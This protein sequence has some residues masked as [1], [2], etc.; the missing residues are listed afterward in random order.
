MLY[1]EFL[2]L[3]AFIETGSKVCGFCL[4]FKAVVSHSRVG[5][6]LGFQMS[7]GSNGERW[8]VGSQIRSNL[9]LC[10]V[11]REVMLEPIDNKGCLR[12]FIVSFSMLESSYIAWKIWHPCAVDQVVMIFEVY[13]FTKLFSGDLVSSASYTFLHSLAVYNCKYFVLQTHQKS[14]CKSLERVLSTHY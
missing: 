11:S 12:P 1:G 13:H 9:S 4:R 3:A 5:I 2:Q 8:T 7:K 10:L 14:S 6:S